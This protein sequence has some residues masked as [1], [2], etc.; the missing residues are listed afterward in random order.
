V[1]SALPGSTLSLSPALKI[2]SAVV[3]RTVASVGPLFSNSRNSNG[4]NSQRFESTTRL[5]PLV[6]GASVSNISET[7]PRICIGRR[8][9]S[10]RANAALIMPIAVSRGGIDEWLGVACAVN[11]SV[12]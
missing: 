7:V 11:T 4:L 1:A 2:V 8:W 5:K 6:S 12:A 3:V 9:S 10:S